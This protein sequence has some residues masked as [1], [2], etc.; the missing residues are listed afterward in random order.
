MANELSDRLDWLTVPELSLEGLRG[1]VVALAFWHAGSAVCGNLLRDLQQL[2]RK[3]ADGLSV[4]A[5]HCPRFEAEREREVVVKAV[6]RLGLRFPVAADRDF[7]AWQHYGVRGW[8]S[9]LLIDAHG[10]VR[11]QFAGDLCLSAL[12]AAIDDLLHEGG[13][14]NSRV[15]EILRPPQVDEQ[16]LPLSFPSGLAISDSHLYIADSGHHRILE[17]THD[18]RVLREFGSGTPGLLDGGSSDA[19][20]CFPSGLLIHR[21]SLYVA[22]TCNH[23]LRRIRLL[24]GEVDTVLGNGRPGPAAATTGDLD[25][26]TP[27]NAPID[28]AGIQDR[29]FVSVSGANQVWEYDLTRERLRVLAGSGDTGV[30]DGVGPFARFAEPAGLVQVQQTLYVLDS[31]G[32]ALRSVHVGDSAVQTLVG[33]GLFD[34]GDKDGPRSVAGL[35]HPLALVLDTGSP[36]LWIADTY[37]NAIRKLRLGGGEVMRLDIPYRLQRPAAIATR[38]GGLWIA[39]TDAHELLHVDVE[40]GK[41]RR[42]AVGE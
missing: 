3:H 18:G 11:E 9:T 35:Q 40:S 12:D 17:C 14:D 8:P 41:V 7:V 22:D 20:F 5:V 21:E 29:L 28:V 4:V 15:F 6:E 24:S 42:I 26:G 32:S 25:R 38:R 16:R 23:A 34:F 19:G 13:E 37:N 31:A 10:R 33:K 39:N 30:V 27:L 1:R 2:Q 36:T